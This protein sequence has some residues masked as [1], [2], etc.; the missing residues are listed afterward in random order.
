LI[1]AYHITIIIFNVKN[2]IV[3]G[4]S[5]GFGLLTVKTLARMGHR[6]YATMRNLDTKNRHAADGLKEWS[7]K[8]QADVRI[9]ELDVTNE[10]S[11][12]EAIRK[13]GIDAGG[14]IDVLINNAGLFM[15][16]LSEAV[17]TH[18]LENLFQINVFGADRVM[19]AVLPYMRR[20]QEGLIVTVSSGLARLH[21]P[22]VGAY[23]A[24][25]A[26]I[27]V[28]GTTYHYELSSFNIDSVIVQPGAMA[29]DI[30]HKQIASDNGG[31]AEAYG[32]RGKLIE[33]SIKKIF[34]T[35][36]QSPDPQT[37]ADAI[38]TIINTPHGE[39]NL[40]NTVGIVGVGPTIESL[41]QQ[42]GAFSKEVQKAVGIN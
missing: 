15:M 19:K 36:P 35:T 12:Q 7:V 13:I 32:T 14:A 31:V 2:I 21:L 28:I 9:Y 5:S 10:G 34:A 18:Q 24:T 23:T 25:K 11:V 40:W 20:R 4:S 29:T 22:Y 1:N 41:N 8:H 3:T 17:S 16:G 30:F 27:D 42:T 38:A 39:R 37:V 33:Q 26:A 6:V